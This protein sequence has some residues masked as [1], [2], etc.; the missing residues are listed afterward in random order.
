M[1]KFAR[2]IQMEEWIYKNES[3]LSDHSDPEEEDKNNLHNSAYATY[4][5]KFSI[6][7]RAKELYPEWFTK[8]KR[9]QS[10]TRHK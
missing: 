4:E 1:M 3:F 8:V 5:T 6:H 2:L 10:D 7:E 9:A